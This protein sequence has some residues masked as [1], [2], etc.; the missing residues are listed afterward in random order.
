MLGE[1]PHDLL[2]QG[3]EVARPRAAGEADVAAV[4][5]LPERDVAAD[6][7]GARQRRRRQ[8]RVV[9]GVEHERG[10]ADVGEPRLRRAAKEPIAAANRIERSG[11]AM[12]ITLPIP[13]GTKKLDTA[14]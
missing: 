14:A 11:A 7:A 13:I 4:R 3:A 10:N 9:A 8:E 12:T 5:R 1:P 6:V 2:G